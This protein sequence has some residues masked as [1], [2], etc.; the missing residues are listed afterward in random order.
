MDLTKDVP[1][2][3]RDEIEGIK[4]LPRAIDKA[5]AQLAGTLG[6]YTYYGCAFNTK[7]FNTFGVTDDEFLDAVRTTED[8][9]GVAE[10]VREFVRPEPDNVR[11]LN[12]WVENNE[13]QT[14]E[15]KDELKAAVE[16][17]DPG[18]T[19]VRT[20]T[21]LIDLEERSPQKE[22]SSAG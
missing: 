2:S 11:A 20:W 22:R 14:A 6:E 4:I 19:G 9:E 17:L 12:D 18:N 21:D 10:W 13:P 15:E 1:R 16:R 3:P 5:R 7:L 8:D